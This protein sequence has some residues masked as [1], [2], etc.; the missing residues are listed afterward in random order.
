MSD[1]DINKLV[2]GA[3]KEKLIS[4][5]EVAKSASMNDLQELLTN[6]LKIFDK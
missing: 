1:D 3:S 4:L 5:V 6:H 2:L